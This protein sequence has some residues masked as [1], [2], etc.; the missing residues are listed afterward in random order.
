MNALT[1]SSGA[2]Q[3]REANLY[4]RARIRQERKQLENGGAKETTRR[5]ERDNEGDNLTKASPRRRLKTTQSAWRSPNAHNWRSFSARYH[6][7]TKL[8]QESEKKQKTKEKEG[9]NKRQTAFKTGTFTP[10]ATLTVFAGRVLTTVF[11]KSS[12]SGAVKK[13]DRSR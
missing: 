5:R 2:Y 3:N 9:L 6:F 13:L 1:F 4:F 8:F 11:V 7:V 12:G 10:R